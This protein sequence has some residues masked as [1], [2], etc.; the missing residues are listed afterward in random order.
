MS[1]RLHVAMESKASPVGEFIVLLLFLSLFFFTFIFFVSRPP[2]PLVSL[3]L[4]SAI[5]YLSP[6][7]PAANL[8]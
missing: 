3:F 2:P 5:P 7:A 4:S 6:S 8:S 1:G